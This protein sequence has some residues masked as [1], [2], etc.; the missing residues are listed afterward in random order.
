[1]NNWKIVGNITKGFGVVF[2]VFGVFA[3]ILTYQSADYYASTPPIG[4]I[5]LS[6]LSAILSPYLLLAA[7]SFVIAWFSIHAAKENP[8]E[9]KETPPIETAEPQPEETKP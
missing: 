7:L 8:D 2:V 4:Y 6:V 5:Q 3:A 9:E 1:M